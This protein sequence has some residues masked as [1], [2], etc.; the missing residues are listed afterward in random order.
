[1]VGKHLGLTTVRV[2]VTVESEGVRAELAMCT[3]TQWRRS[4][5]DT[6]HHHAIDE[7]PSQKKM[8]TNSKGSRLASKCHQ[9]I[10]YLQVGD[11]PLIR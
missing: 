11:L 9:S 3:R 6:A 5:A 2:V 1:M 4:G 10:H 7:R 8:S